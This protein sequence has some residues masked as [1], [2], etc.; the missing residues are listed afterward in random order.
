MVLP[1]SIP[2][3]L[4]GGILAMSRAIGEA[5]PILVVSGVV[6]IMNTPRNLMSDFSAMPLQVYDWVQRPQEEF[7]QV[8]AAGIM[9]LLVVLL[10]FNGAAVFV[11]QRLQ[12]RLHG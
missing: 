9:V 7:H 6:F 11:R 10:V 5:A 4:T 2:G 3:I 8:A 1:A 12:G